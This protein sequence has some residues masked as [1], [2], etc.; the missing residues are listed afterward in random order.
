MDWKHYYTGLQWL[1][2]TIAVR[3]L[4]L[5]RSHYTCLILYGLSS[6]RN[7]EGISPSFPRCLLSF[8][9][10]TIKAASPLTW[11]PYPHTC[12]AAIYRPVVWARHQARPSTGWLNFQK[13][14]APNKK[15]YTQSGQAGRPEM[16]TEHYENR[17]KFTTSLMGLQIGFF[18]LLSQDNSWLPSLLIPAPVRMQDLT[19]VHSGSAPLQHRATAFVM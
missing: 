12:P 13:K 18:W 14:P 16:L 4:M 6:A 3:G 7:K 11:L 17:S 15:Q 10:D 2:Q 8:S 19:A 5:P 9:G 1:Q